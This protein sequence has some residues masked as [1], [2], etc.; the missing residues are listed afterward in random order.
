MKGYVIDESDSLSALAFADDLILMVTSKTKAQT[1][2]HHTEAYLN[3][4]G[5][6][7]AAEKCAPFEIRPMKDTWY[8]KIPDLRLLNG[9]EIPY[10]AAD[11]SLRYLSGHISPWPGLQYKDIVDEMASTLERCRGVLLKPHQKLS[12]TASHIPPHFLH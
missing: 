5:M 3:S 7:I 2:L 1:L 8:M 6:R 9:D 10:S 12:L 11:S 4:L